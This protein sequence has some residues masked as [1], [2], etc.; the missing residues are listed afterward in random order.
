VSQ[1]VVA[2]EG[3]GRSRRPVYA[4]EGPSS[5]AARDPIAM[6]ERLAIPGMGPTGGAGPVERRLITEAER[7]IRA[8]ARP[9]PIAPRPASAVQRAWNGKSPEQFAQEEPVVVEA[10]TPEPS[11]VLE[12]RAV[13]LGMLADAV[14]E[15]IEADDELSRAEHL[16]DQAQIRWDGA[17]AALDAAYRALDDPPPA[18]VEPPADYSDSIPGPSE[19]EVRHERLLEE[20]IVQPPARPTSA[21]GGRATPDELQASRKRGQANMQAQRRAVELTSAAGAKAPN[22]AKG[23]PGKRSTEARARMSAAMTASYARRKATAS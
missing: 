7:E 8:E 15:A 14:V 12:S 5:A 9:S 11:P 19:A 3:E 20:P 22:P 23:R 4:D 2:Y 6:H 21:E 18:I 1:R 17:R 16:A 13:T 10:V